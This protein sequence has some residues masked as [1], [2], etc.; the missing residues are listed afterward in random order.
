MEP[1]PFHLVNILLNAVVCHM[2]VYTVKNMNPNS[3]SSWMFPI[4]TCALFTFHP[5][6]TEVVATVVGRADLLSALFILV[7]FLLHV[8]VMSDNVVY[9]KQFLYCLI[10]AWLAALSKE[11]GLLVLGLCGAHKVACLFFFKG[12]SSS[13]ST[14]TSNSMARFTILALTGVLYL[15]FR[16]SIKMDPTRAHY[17][18]PQTIP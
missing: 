13:S 17:H 7:A 5:I 14:T 1:M 2:T 15:L 12:P 4:V 3:T 16:K 10:C 6:H 18:R 11:T 9:S 8:N